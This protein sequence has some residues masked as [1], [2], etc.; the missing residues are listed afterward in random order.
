MSG[1][2]LQHT[3]KYV[4]H[5]MYLHWRA[6]YTKYYN[7]TTKYAKIERDV[8]YIYIS[9]VLCTVA[10]LIKVHPGTLVTV[11]EGPWCPSSPLCK[12][13]LDQLLI[14][15]STFPHSFPHWANLEGS[16]SS[17]DFFW[18]FRTPATQ[19]CRS[20]FELWRSWPC[21][22]G[23][24]RQP[25]RWDPDFS[26]LKFLNFYFLKTIQTLLTSWAKSFI[27]SLKL[28]FAPSGGRS[29]KKNIKREVFS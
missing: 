7:K 29:E 6:G 25:E 9:S 4:C 19:H 24:F 15:W 28:S 23:C 8:K 18:A 2:I 3:W 14:F 1:Y 11:K 27:F 5:M 10:L 21:L 22:L 13:F 16:N 26:F 20:P 12:C 17:H